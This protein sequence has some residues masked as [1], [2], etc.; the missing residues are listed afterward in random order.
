MELSPPRPPPLKFTRADD[1]HSGR[2]PPPGEWAK[3]GH[4]RPRAWGLRPAHQKKGG[5]EL[6]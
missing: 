6:L 4:V 5:E 3:E 2:A 1:H